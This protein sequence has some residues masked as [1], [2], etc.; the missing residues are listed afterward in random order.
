MMIEIREAGWPS[1]IYTAIMQQS[2]CIPSKCFDRNQRPIE[3]DHDSYR[4]RLLANFNKHFM[5]VLKG[6]QEE[7]PPPNFLVNIMK[8]SFLLLSTGNSPIR[9]PPLF[10]MVVHAGSRK[11][12]LKLL[13]VPANLSII[14]WDTGK[15]HHFRDI[16]WNIEAETC[17]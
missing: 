8:L 15:F 16:S 4:A 10:Q 1:N 12:P 9:L 2:L 6:F 14:S 5:P 7:I 11:C 3:F 13:A 17:A